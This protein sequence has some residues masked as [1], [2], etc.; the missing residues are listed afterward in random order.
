V[1]PNPVEKLKIYL[2]LQKMGT[3]QTTK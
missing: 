2:V 1:K 3:K